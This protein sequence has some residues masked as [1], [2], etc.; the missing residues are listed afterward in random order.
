L[1]FQLALLAASAAFAFASSDRA[2]SFA[3]APKASAEA[4]AA[5]RME[6]R[7]GTPLAITRTGCS[8]GGG[9][10]LRC[11]GILPETTSSRQS[12]WWTSAQP[13]ST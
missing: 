13:S 1:S 11:A 3:A 12:G 6:R 7:I 5:T 9:G 10:A 4:Q 8:R 2:G